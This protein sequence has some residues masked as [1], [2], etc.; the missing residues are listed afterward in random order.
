MMTAYN[1]DSNTELEDEQ[2]PVE[3]VPMRMTKTVRRSKTMRGP[4]TGKPMMT[5][6]PPDGNAKLMMQSGLNL[7]PPRTMMKHSPLDLRSC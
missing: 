1:R 6:R 3:A 7:K 4:K 2:D 5:M